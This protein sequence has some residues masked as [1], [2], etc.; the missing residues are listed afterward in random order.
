MASKEPVGIQHILPHSRTTLAGRVLLFTSIVMLPLQDY[1]PQVAG[2]STS[3]L[4]FAAL[5]VY[6]IVNCPHSLGKI[7]SH[8]VFVAAYVFIGVSALLE[9]SSP[10]SRYSDII[11]FGH[12]ITGA[13]CI[14]AVCRDR[15]TLAAG[16]YG[17]IATALWVAVVLY[18]TAYGTLQGMAASS[19][20][21]HEADKIRAQ[22]F[23]NKPMKANLDALG[24]ICA[25]GA[26]VAFALSLSD[27][28]K[29]FR[30]L[31]L[32]IVAFCLVASFL[33]MSRGAA[34][35]CLVCLAAI[36]YTQGVR[37]GK[38]LIFAC[39][40]GAVVYM[41]VP[42]AVWSRMVYTTEVGESGKMESRA[43]LYTTALNRLPEYVVAG[44]GAGNF[45]EKWGYEKWYTKQ[46]HGVVVP[47]AAHNTPLAITVY[48][49]IMGLSI[50]AW[51]IWCLYRSIPFGCGRDGLALA[52]LGIILSLSLYM[53]QI[54][55]FYDKQFALGIGLLVGARQWIWP[56]GV[57]ERRADSS[58]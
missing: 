13:V 8:P 30:L 32:G 39:V 48:W 6:V 12:M 15:S 37:H 11:R 44:V 54:H 42:D 27:K 33:P 1:F 58:P 51:F 14:A 19:G 10:L 29:H 35:V 36:S 53:M 41:V 46:I 4:I 55:G 24:F 23:E 49:G 25:Q 7:W 28:V 52:L 17:Y 16:L 3:F 21:F 31:L 9:F 2:M 57:V 50:F 34:M 40:L 56:R 45:F 22:A 20:D 5:A 26:I 43:K 38:V 47:I 18:L